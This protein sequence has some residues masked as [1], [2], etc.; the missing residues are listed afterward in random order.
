MVGVVGPDIG[1]PFYYDKE[2]VKVIEFA[3]KLVIR[4][5]VSK[6]RSQE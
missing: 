2:N 6:K 1:N 5:S 3:A 4:D